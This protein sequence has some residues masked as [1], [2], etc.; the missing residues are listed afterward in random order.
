[1][2]QPVKWKDGASTYLVNAP[3][4]LETAFLA[5][6]VSVGAS[7]VPVEGWGSQSCPS[8]DC[9]FWALR[10]RPIVKRLMHVLHFPGIALS[11]LLVGL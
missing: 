4:G 1:M 2:E 5:L 10:L 11:R 8:A 7:L 3:A 9:L 6:F